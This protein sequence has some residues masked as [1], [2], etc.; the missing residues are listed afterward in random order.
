[1][2]QVDAKISI[3]VYDCMHAGNP[4]RDPGQS[5]EQSMNYTD[6]QGKTYTP[7]EQCRYGNGYY[8]HR[9]Y[10]PVMVDGW[11]KMGM[12]F[13]SLG[14]GSMLAVTG[15]LGVVLNLNVMLMLP[16]SGFVLE[17]SLGL[18]YEL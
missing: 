9:Y 11:K 13:S 17:P 4:D 18:A 1:V 10:N 14:A 16:A 15:Q 5:S 6:A 2:A 12:A 8:N 7:Y 3:P